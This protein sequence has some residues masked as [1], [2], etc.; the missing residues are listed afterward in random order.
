MAADNQSS[1]KSFA[2]LS[3]RAKA[4]ILLAII[5]TIAVIFYFGLYMGIA[6]DLVSAKSRYDQL[7]GEM[8]EAETRRQEYL[9]IQQKLAS[10]GEVD[11]RN[12]RILPE[13]AEIP[14]FLQDLNRS[15]EAA[16]LEI[17]LVEPR[18]EE[19]SE[20]VVRVPVTL[21]VAGR[22]HQLLKFV[23]LVSRLDRA[24]N[25]ENIKISDPKV[26]SDEVSLRADLLATTFRRSSE[27]EKTAARS[28]NKQN[29]I[30]AGEATP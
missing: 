25:L 3:S 12:Y 13:Q 8:Q 5:A 28:D 18:P 26:G 6:G 15:A 19:V 4:G 7:T 11:R 2:K 20:Y 30:P 23:Y 14:S 21:R 29:G 10:R 22:Y 17:E 16:G 24:I 1:R 9:A 27:A